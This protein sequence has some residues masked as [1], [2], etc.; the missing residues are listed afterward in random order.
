MEEEWRTI[1]GLPDYSASNKGRIRRD[2]AKYR[3]KAKPGMIIEGS[4]NLGYIFLMCPDRK[5][6]SFHRLVALTFL[7]PPPSP[8]SVVCHYDGVRDNNAVENLRWA[9]QAD[10]MADRKRHGTSNQGEASGRAKL[11][12]KQALDI[13]KSTDKPK[14]LAERYGVKVATIYSIR[15]RRSWFHLSESHP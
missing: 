4:R 11:T 3:T 7:G 2:T 12:T 6:R 13:L 10:N 9:T 5:Y 8:K 15:Q 1:P 14:V